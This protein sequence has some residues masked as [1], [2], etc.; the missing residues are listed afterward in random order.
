[1]KN[2]ITE[3]IFVIDKSGS[4]SGLEA[5]TI[6]GFNSMLEKQRSETGVCHISTVFFSEKSQV[7]HDRQNIEKV[8]PLTRK[9][10]VPGG[11]TAL[12]DTLGD[13]INHTVNVQKVLAEDEKAGNVVF[14]IITDGE[15][16]ASQRFSSEKIKKMISFEKEK[17]GWEFIFLGAN[18]DAIKTAQTYGISEDRAS[19]FICDSMGVNLNFSCVSQAV[20][21]VRGKGRISK[22]WKE[23]ICDDFENRSEI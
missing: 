19:N 9:N 3:L 17:Y 8:E 6:G 11:C 12:L 4:M 18:I 7:I 14:V 16:N 23:K 20:S 2:N 21:E 15:E 13:V 22:K 10:Y 1:M 5:D